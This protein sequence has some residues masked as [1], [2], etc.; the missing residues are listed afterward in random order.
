MTR[1]M[2]TI[3]VVLGLGCGGGK[4]GPTPLDG[5]LDGATD[6]D[7]S[8]EDGARPDGS[9]DADGSAAGDGS[10][11]DAGSGLD[12]SRDAYC[13]GEGPP[14]VLG[15]GTSEAAE[16]TGR[17][18]ARV[19]RYALCSCARASI[20]DRFR[21]DSFDSS[22]GPYTA[23]EPGGSV[24]VNGRYENTNVTEIGGSL[25]VS[26]TTRV[27][28]SSTH[29]IASDARFNGPVTVD[30][31]VEIGRDAYVNGNVDGSSDFVVGRDLYLSPGSRATGEI[32]VNGTEREDASFE[33][34]PPCACEPEDLVDIA[35]IV[36]A[37]RD[38]NHNTEI[39]LDVAALERPASAVDLTL[40]CGRFFVS[41]IDTGSAAI[42]LR[43]DGRTLLYVGG[44]IRV[45]NPLRVLVGP[46]GELDLFVEGSIE[47]TDALELGTVDRPAAVR[48][49]VGGSAPIVLSSGTT[50]AGNLY[51]PFAEVQP[52]D[53]VTVF[54]SIFAGS[55]ASSG[56]VF[57]HY[58]EAVL[59]ADAECPSDRPM[60]D[61]GVPPPS[62]CTDCRD[63]GGTEGCSGGTCGA[64]ARDGDCC[65]PLV[66][67]GGRCSATL[68]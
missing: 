62:T 1:A 35:A 22:S 45:E 57:I 68:F 66:C 51:A 14:I 67:V 2:T 42:T 6:R 38:D 20:Q 27:T 33:I 55:F 18:A 49:Y 52:A 39:E 26:S 32:F 36:A 65:A 16:C 41:A 34:A 21:T 50:F 25:T 17:T 13:A 8:S 30:D 24:G 44:D 48:T 23:G 3:L 7:G 43:V 59:R 12:A 64:C 53:S 29:D 28:M 9:P 5:A 19:F 63:C 40:P 60:T 61:G 47:A 56:D 4:G 58:D 46:E 54:G 37:G 31:R 11:A 15:D 10:I